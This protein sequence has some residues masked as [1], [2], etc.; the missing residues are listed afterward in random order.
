MQ[1]WAAVRTPKLSASLL[2]CGGDLAYHG[3]EAQEVDLQIFP[4]SI[5]S[6]CVLLRFK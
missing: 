3:K 5:T 1:R 2:I 4:P 6:A